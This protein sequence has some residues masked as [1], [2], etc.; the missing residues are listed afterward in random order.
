MK[1]DTSEWT[2]GV[3]HEWADWHCSDLPSEYTRSP[4]HTIVNSNGIAAQIKPDF[5]KYGG[6]INTIPSETMEDQITQ[7]V[8]LKSKLSP[9]VNYRS[10]LHIHIRVP[11]LKNDLNMLKLVQTY[12]HEKLPRWIDSVDPLP[13]AT[14]PAEKKRL[15]R[16]KVSHRTLLTP[17][18][19]KYQMEAETLQEFFEREVPR[20][21]KGQVMWHAQPRLA[22]GLR[23]LL[24]TDTVEFRHFFGTL[25]EEELLGAMK[26]CRK[27]LLYALRDLSFKPS[28]NLVSLPVPK[29]FNE[30]LEIK[31]QAT[32]NHN[33]LSK[34]ECQRNIQMILDGEFNASIQEYKEATKR[35]GCL[36]G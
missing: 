30:E 16:N 7:L 22:V 8:D 29:P 9:S 1:V 36:S 5:Y 14:T 26:W 35:A 33:G 10:N 21:K 27:F 20:S 17:Q 19:L 23:Q 31:Y 2:Y 32:A 28:R 13:K 3:E 4:D 11:G 15:R 18:R 24:Q 25:E 6:E 34:K 12:I